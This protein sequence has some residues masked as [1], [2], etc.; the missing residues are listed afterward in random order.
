MTTFSHETNP[1]V[2]FAVRQLNLADAQAV[3]EVYDSQPKL[4]LVKKHS[5]APPYAD[6]FA[7]L[8]SADCYAY[9]AFS[10]NELRAFAV[11]YL[12]PRL[13]A[14]TL[15]LACCRP[16]GGVYR[17]E[18]SGIAAVFDAGLAHAERNSRYMFFTIRSANKKW[19][20]DTMVSEKMGRFFQYRST[21]A[22]RI[23]AG[24]R[25]QFDLINQLVLNSQPASTDVFLICAIAPWGNDAPLNAKP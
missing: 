7:S 10:N 2:S 3:Q 19:N 18:K 14:T 1:C 25:S 4:M 11:F 17:P 15:V 20:H 8:L 6:T 24:E 9:G 21:V 5:D 13:P 16:T 23:P 22:E 12:W